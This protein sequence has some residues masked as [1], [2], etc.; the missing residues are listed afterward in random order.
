MARSRAP[1]TIAALSGLITPSLPAAVNLYRGPVVTGDPTDAIFLG[2][3]GD[4]GG[5]FETVINHTQTWAGIG[6]RAREE[7]F[8][9]VC[10]AVVLNNDIAAAQIKAYDM[11]GTVEDVVRADPSLGLGPPTVSA[12]FRSEINAP[13]LFT[14]PTDTGIQ[15]RLVFH[16]HVTCRI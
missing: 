9:V 13:K 8:D 12:M 11:M 2:Y 16:V 4:P 1:A 6:N 5:W 15:T 7:I 10:S 3:D 14:E